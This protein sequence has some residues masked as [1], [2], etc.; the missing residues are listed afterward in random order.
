[1]SRVFAAD[2]TPS[3]YSNP[4]GR[5]VLKTEIS[6]IPLLSNTYLH[7]TFKMFATRTEGLVQ[8][9]AVDASILTISAR[10]GGLGAD[11]KGRMRSAKIA[12]EDDAYSSPTP[13]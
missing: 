2:D 3:S 12:R 8:A 11:S 1:M 13:G 4:K 6:T 5:P 9:V 7:N 10:Y